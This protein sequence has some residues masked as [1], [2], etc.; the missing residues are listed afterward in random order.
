MICTRSDAKYP[1]TI[2]IALDD[3][4]KKVSF[5]SCSFLIIILNGKNLEINATFLFFLFWWLKETST[6]C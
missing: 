3:D 2:A 5:I 1:D 4:H 6:S